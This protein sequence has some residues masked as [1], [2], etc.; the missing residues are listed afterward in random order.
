MVARLKDVAA[1]AGVSV[2]TV[3][4]VVNKQPHV[5]AS[6][7]ARVEA[8]IAELRYRP[9]LSARELKYGRTGFLALALPELE[10]PYFAELASRIVSIASE[11]DRLVLL[12]DTRADPAAEMM[13]C[14]GMRSHVIDGVIFSPLALDAEQI[15]RRADDVP[16]VLL[17]ERAVPPGYDH[18]A[19]DS[20]EA[21]EAA[22]AHLIRL[23]RRRIAA[24]GW[25]SR[26]GTASVRHS[27]YRRALAA[28]GL[29]YDPGLVVGV[30]RYQRADGR[31]ALESLLELPDPPDAVFCFNDMLAIGALK[32]CA[33]AGIDVP[34]EIA[35]MGFDDVTEAGYTN[36][37]LST[38]S[39]DTD[40][41]ARE[42]VRLLLR[43]IDDPDAEPERVRVPWQLRLRQSTEGR[44][45]A[46]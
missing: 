17:G 38:V 34:G 11:H 29:P 40:H 15:A 43:R 19:V 5:A 27:G 9:N 46:L 6:T 22:T 42:A 20:V 7:R 33:E 28:A 1:R 12:D 4:N 37:T 3:S 21:A 10:M 26:Q 41:L 39:V 2:K 13:V 35:V 36:P 45:R 32:H 8:A 44:R 25:E 23:G 30:P 24:V 16:M 31:L 14:E 18:V